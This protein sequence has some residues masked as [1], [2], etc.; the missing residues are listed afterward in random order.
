MKIPT[1]LLSLP[2]YAPHQAWIRSNVGCTP[3]DPS[4]AAPARASLTEASL[5]GANLRWANLRGADLTEASLTGADLTGATLIGA[6]L[7]GAEL[8]VADL[9]GAV[10]LGATMPDGRLWERYR[11][12]HLDGLCSS[13]AVQARA[14]AAW[15]HKEWSD[16][17]MHAAHGWTSL[18]GIVDETLHRDVACWIALHDSDQL[19]HPWRYLI[20]PRFGA[21]GVGT[22]VCDAMLGAEQRDV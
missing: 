6:D 14:A 20:G 3:H 12:A 4:D 9:T 11:A 21:A 2:W 17:P 19:P 7:T 13:T 5:T 1:H 15:G 16:C 10:L 22:G 8:S 18:S